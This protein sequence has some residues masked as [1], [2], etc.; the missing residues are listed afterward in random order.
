MMVRQRAWSD[1]RLASLV[2]PWMFVK[3]SRVSWRATL[4]NL[5]QGVYR[6]QQ[7]GGQIIVEQWP[8]WL[9]PRSPFTLCKRTPEALRIL[10][11]RRIP[12]FSLS[13][14]PT[15]RQFYRVNCVDCDFSLEPCK[16]RIENDL[17]NFFDD[18]RS[19]KI[20]HKIV[21]L[22]FWWVNWYARFCSSHWIFL[23][24]FRLGLD[25]D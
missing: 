5:E 24:T 17:K 7:K 19:C 16:I 21:I 20:V 25:L 13:K 1:V 15:A 6:R 2:K 10:N 9:L 8:A 12:L 3:V 4:S 14:R 23:S 18:L 11:T 22:I